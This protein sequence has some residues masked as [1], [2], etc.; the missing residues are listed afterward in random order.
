MSEL[1]L[2]QKIRLK[3]ETTVGGTTSFKN[4]ASEISCSLDLSFDKIDL[5]HKDNGNWKQ[6]LL[7]S[8]SATVPWEGFSNFSPPANTLGFTDLYAKAISRQRFNFQ[9]VF[10]AAHD[11]TIEF[12]GYIDGFKIDGQNDQGSKVSFNILVDEEPTLEV[13]A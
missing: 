6:Q 11:V 5:A 9:I 7:G 13:A 1:L 10:D 8:G 3:I 12:P 2:G 4:L